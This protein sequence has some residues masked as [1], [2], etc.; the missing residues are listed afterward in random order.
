V[1]TPAYNY[2]QIM[3]RLTLDDPRLFLPDPVYRTR[4]GRYLVREAIDS[5]GLWNDIRDIPFFALPPDRRGQD[6]VPL[7]GFSALSLEPGRNLTGLWRC[8]LRENGKAADEFEMDL[9]ERTNLVSGTAAFGVIR[10]GT[11]RDAELSIRIED[12]S[13]TYI[14]TAQ[15]LPDRLTGRVIEQ[16]QPGDSQCECTR[17]TPLAHNSPDVITLY[18]YEEA[19]RIQYTTDSHAPSARAVGKVWRNPMSILVL[20]RG[21]RPKP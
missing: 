5:A 17:A 12:G 2:N 15:I 3:Y 18:Q 19:G 14:F 8:K 10:Q 6:T 11:I 4:D 16:G 1:K 20:D 21:A 7:S 9:L 13:S